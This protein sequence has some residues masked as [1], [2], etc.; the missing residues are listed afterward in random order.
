M[1]VFYRCVPITEIKTEPN[2]RKADGGGQ[3]QTTLQSVDDLYR[4]PKNVLSK[5][6]WFVFILRGSPE[7]KQQQ[8]SIFFPEKF[9][10]KISVYCKLC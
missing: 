5:S 2:K 9:H 10:L 7:R 8:N 1:K 3:A 4:Y 6:D